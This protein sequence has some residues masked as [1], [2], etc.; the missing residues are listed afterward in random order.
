MIVAFCLYKYFP[1]GG[2]QRDFFRIAQNV[3]S[4]G[5]QIRVYVKEWVGD[6]PASFEIIEVPVTSKTNHGQGNQF[7]QWTQNHLKDNPVD[8]VVGFNKMPGLDV[9][10]AADVCYEE[11]VSTEKHGFKAWLYRLTSRYRHFSEFEKATFAN[12]FKT[13]LLMIAES[14]IDYFK[15]HYGT[16]DE[17]F[18]L[19]PPGIAP[20]RKY[21]NQP[22]GIRERVRAENGLTPDQKV[23]LQVGS[24]YKLKGVDRSLKAIAALPSE[25][26][27]QVVY[28]VAG[29]DNPAKFMEQARH[30]GI[31]KNV[32]ILGARNDVPE[33]MAAADL[34]LHPA[35]FENTGTVILEAV[36]AGLPVIVSGVCGYAFYIKRADCG[37]VVDEPFLQE[38]FNK[39]LL[40]MLTNDDYRSR[41]VSN[42][43]QF[44]DTQDLY[45]MIDRATEVIL[46]HSKQ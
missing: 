11:K 46:N 27:N 4:K 8:V 1:Y 35:Y 32:R 30:L 3:E 5:H 37:I 33:L 29:Q 31:E 19:L 7:A 45:S 9:Y 16:E 41:C 22:E 20:D 21:T 10:Y 38:S 44:A 34:Y 28:M 24:N 25:L 43:K 15:K 13:K 6:K 26:R 2:L 40:E 39:A 14:Q 36:V 23:L 17:R 18:I 12:G 42:A